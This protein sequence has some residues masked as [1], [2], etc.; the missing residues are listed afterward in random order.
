MPLR[1]VLVEPL[2]PQNT[3]STARLT[4]ATNSELHLIEPLGFE[5]SDRY[6]KRAGLD[7]WP[8][9]KLTIHPSWEKFLESTGANHG[10]LWF[11]TTHAE[12][13]Y[14]EVQYGPDDFLVFGNESRG[15]APHFHET[16]VGRRLA[17]PMENANVRSLNLSNCTAIALYEARRQ[18]GLIRHRQLPRAELPNESSD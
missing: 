3:G 17:I 14:S 13:A 5:I 8:E 4:A 9:V 1:I 18:L 2:I 10:N 6:L 11:F 12:H 7:Y 16:Y 15:L